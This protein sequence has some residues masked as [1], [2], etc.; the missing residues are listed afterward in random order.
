MRAYILGIIGV[1]I[2]AITFPMT[3]LAVG[4]ESAPQL[5]PWFSA[6]GRAAVAGLLSLAYLALTAQFKVANRPKRADWLPLVITAAGVVFGFPLLTAFALRYVES[7]HAAVLIGFLPLATAAIGAWLARQRPSM[8]FWLCAL[9]GSGLVVAYALLHN[10]NP[11]PN[12]TLSLMFHP[13]DGLLVLAVLCAAM[14]YAYGAVVSVRLGGQQVICWALVIS[15]PI[16]IPA[17]FYGCPQTPISASA[18][19]GFLYISVFSMWLG[20]FA[21]YRALALGGTVRISQ[22]QLLQPLLSIAFAVP[23]LG[24]RL[25]L[26]T[27][28][29]AIAVIATVFV[30]KKMPVRAN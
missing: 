14:G 5:S 26:M 1:V 8:G 22:I 23:I 19:L 13:A 24:E 17:A 4:T 30:G 2:F 28:V 11:N 3:R 18:W 6:L 12:S 20:F 21:W 27:L 29:F 25:D 7:I 15:L 9:T 10:P 16:T